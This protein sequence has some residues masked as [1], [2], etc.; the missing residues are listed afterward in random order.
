MINVEWKENGKRKYRDFLSEQFANDFVEELKEKGCTDIE[1]TEVN[2]SKE[3]LI[4]WMEGEY[5][6]E[7][8]KRNCNEL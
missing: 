4:Y 5:D 3:W 6:Y 8:C 7:E 2:L 1:V